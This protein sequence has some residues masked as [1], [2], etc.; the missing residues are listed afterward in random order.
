MFMFFPFPFFHIHVCAKKS[1]IGTG[2]E[3]SLELHE[4]YAQLYTCILITFM[5]VVGDIGL[6][7]MTARI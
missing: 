2:L 6:E 1:N 4:P 7:P 5:N 3:P